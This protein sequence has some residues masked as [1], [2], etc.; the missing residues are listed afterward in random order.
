MTEAT[1]QITVRELYTVEYINPEVVT[2]VVEF[3]I[4]QPIDGNNANDWIF[5]TNSVHWLKKAIRL[6]LDLEIDWVAVCMVI[7][8]LRQ[9]DQLQ[10]E[11]A[12]LTA[13]LQR[14]I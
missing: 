2:S 12:Q 6:Y 4:V 13:Q 3:G 9:K 5:D 14:F 11:N 1:F 7:D 8:L 10:R